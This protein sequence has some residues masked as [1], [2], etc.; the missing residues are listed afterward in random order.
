[1]KKRTLFAGL[2]GLASGVVLAHN[3][4]VLTKEGIKL[5]IRTGHKVRELSQQAIED[6][7]DLT[8]EVNQEISQQQSSEHDQEV[9]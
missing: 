6:L 1:M 8:A 4:R 2:V 7:G 5:G 3:W 9:M